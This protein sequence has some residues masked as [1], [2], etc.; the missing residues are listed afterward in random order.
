MYEMFL[1][2]FANAMQQ[3]NGIMDECE[4]KN[5]S[6]RVTDKQRTSQFR[7]QEKI[8]ESRKE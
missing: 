3:Y 7:K 5:S 6:I 2:V 1:E 4:D 8:K